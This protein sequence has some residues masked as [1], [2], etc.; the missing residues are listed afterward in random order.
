M[1]ADAR[2]WRI[3][4]V[5]DGLVNAQLAAAVR[6]DLLSLLDEQGYGVIVMPPP[7]PHRLLLEVIADQVAEFAHHGYA[8][9]AIGAAELSGHGLHWRSF[10]RLL[11]ARGTATIPRHNLRLEVTGEQERRRL[12]DLLSRYDLPEPERQRW[13]G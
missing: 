13:R 12:T 6:F 8:V 10:S 7:G 5:P 11:Q 3:A 4:L 1:T 2:G 9:V